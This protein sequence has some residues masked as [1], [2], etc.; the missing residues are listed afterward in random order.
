MKLNFGSAPVGSAQKVGKNQKEIDP[1]RAFNVS[2]NRN[3]ATIEQ[4][5]G[6]SAVANI[7]VENPALLSVKILFNDHSYASAEN[8]EVKGGRIT[9][10]WKVTPYKMGTFTSGQYDVEIRYGGGF[11][12]K[13]TSSLKIVAVGGDRNVSSFG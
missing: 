12:G 7:T 5:V 8:V 4:V 10:Q 2:W 3:T 13:T 1:K 6:I 9:A 11:S